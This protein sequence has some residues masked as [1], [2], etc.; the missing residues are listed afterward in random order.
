TNY[1]LRRFYERFLEETMADSSWSGL[2]DGL[3]IEEVKQ[4]IIRTISELKR[5]GISSEQAEE[6]IDS[7]NYSP[8]HKALAHLLI[9]SDQELA[10]LSAENGYPCLTYE[11]RLDKASEILAGKT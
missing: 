11:A 7:P 9:R 10:K 4:T 5:S 3:S 1:E 2:G 6:I 8:K